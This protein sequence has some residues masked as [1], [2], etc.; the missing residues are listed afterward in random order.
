MSVE[1]TT[2][3]HTR[4][5]LAAFR[6]GQPQ[7][8]QNLLAGRHTLVVMPTG[9]GKSLIFQLASLHRPGLTLVISSLIAL[10]QDQVTSLTDRG[11]PATYI[12]STL[13]TANKTAGCGRRWPRSSSWSTWHRNACG[14]GL[15]SPAVTGSSTLWADN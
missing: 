11:I 4:F 9:A 1:I 6:P 7:A 13:R 15:A 8:I 3:L 12:N 2:T 14:V 5:G 10:M